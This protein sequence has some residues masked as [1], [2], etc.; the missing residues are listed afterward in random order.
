M[1]PRSGIVQ[2]H[3]LRRLNAR[4][5][6]RA[7]LAKGNGIPVGGCRAGVPRFDRQT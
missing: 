4:G 3:P 1:R 2:R 5:A 6:P 7:P